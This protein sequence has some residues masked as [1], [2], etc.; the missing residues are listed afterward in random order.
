MAG[1]V[2]ALPEGALPAPGA[3]NGIWQRL[4]GRIE[5]AADAGRPRPTSTRGICERGSALSLGDDPVKPVVFHVKPRA[6]AA[7]PVAALTPI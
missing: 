5:L 6:V 1:A 4:A 7:Q 3:G 2:L